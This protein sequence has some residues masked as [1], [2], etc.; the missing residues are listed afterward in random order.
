MNPPAPGS[1]PDQHDADPLDLERIL[2]GAFDTLVRGKQDRRHPYH[3]PVLATTDT[4][5]FPD[6]RTVVL[7]AV[8]PDAS[9]LRCHTD[10]RSPKLAHLLRTPRAAW[11]FYDPRARVQLRI[12]GETH[13]L[14][15]GPEVDSAWAD[16]R[17]FSRRCYLAPHA[18]GSP[19]ESAAGPDPNLPDDLV[20]HN[21]DPVRA[22]LGRRH[23]AIIVTRIHTIDWLRLGAKGHARARFTRAG[24]GWEKH[25]IRP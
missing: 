7:R 22:E 20:E 14:T 24:V 10:A 6:A 5:G 11:L 19:A 23:F 4:E 25:W 1:A 3:Q 2:V 8:D 12:T 13:A 15:E 18:P 9:T 16:T 21:P 17:L